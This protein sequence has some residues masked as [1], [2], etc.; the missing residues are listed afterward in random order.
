VIASVQ[1]VHKVDRCIGRF[2]LSWREVIDIGHVRHHEPWL[3][4]A[5]QQRREPRRLSL[6][7]V[8]DE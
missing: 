1:I 2:N 8:D 4:G 3:S 6:F 5:I 7:P